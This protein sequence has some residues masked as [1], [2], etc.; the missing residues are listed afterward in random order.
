MKLIWDLKKKNKN[1]RP[2][3][4]RKVKIQSR[5]VDSDSKAN[6]KTEVISEN[7]WDSDEI[8]AYQSENDGAKQEEETGFCGWSERD[9]PW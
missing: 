9:H 7:E 3:E 4:L 1:K 2:Q 6:L 5:T 8:V